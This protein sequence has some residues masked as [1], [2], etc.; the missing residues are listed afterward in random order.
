MVVL[1]DRTGAK[2]D[3]SKIRRT[4]VLQ[5]TLVIKTSKIVYLGV[6]LD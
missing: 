6:T 4:T 2:P 1:A 5:A 3:T